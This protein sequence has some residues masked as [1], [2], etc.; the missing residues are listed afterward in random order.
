MQGRVLDFSVSANEGLISGTDGK[1]YRFK[2]DAWKKNTNPQ[3]GMLINFEIDQLYKE[4]INIRPI[5]QKKTIFSSQQ[6][7]P[8]WQFIF[9]FFDKNGLPNEKRPA[10]KANYRKL[11][12]WQK[13]KVSTNI[14]A[15]LFTFFYFLYL[16]M[17][18]KAITLFALS[19]IVAAIAA[20]YLPNTNYLPLILLG[21]LAS[22][23]AN[24]AYY[25]HQK[26]N[27][28]SFNIFEGLF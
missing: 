19:L 2:G 4:A 23:T 13:I 26:K 22:A 7:K 6:L 18:R 3:K 1:R 27:S 25:L 9:G 5:S 21:S 10:Y 15:F 17:W 28:K 12:Y 14:F 20:N 11:T 24:I 16:G 8:K